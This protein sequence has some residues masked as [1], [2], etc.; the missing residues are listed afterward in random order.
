MFEVN[1]AFKKRL[2]VVDN[3]YSNPDK[4]RELALNQEYENGSDWYKG[5]RTFNNFLF[6]QTKHAFED[7]MGIK[8]REWESHGMNGKFQYC[9]PEDMLVYHYDAYNFEIDK[10]YDWVVVDIFW[11]IDSDFEVNYSRLKNQY[12]NKVN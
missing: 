10:V 3:F 2:F 7:I 12:S 9:L 8:I 6:P 11:D 1:P 4:I 5:R